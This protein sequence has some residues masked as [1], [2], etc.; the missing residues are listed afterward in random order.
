[1]KA[2]ADPGQ[3]VEVLPEAAQ[4]VAIERAAVEV[5]PAAHHHML[6]V[7]AVVTAQ[8]GSRSCRVAPRAYR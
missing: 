5:L 8:S 3:G 4:G 6:I 7:G 1:M 2:R